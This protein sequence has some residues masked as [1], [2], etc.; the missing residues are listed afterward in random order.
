ML[1]RSAEDIQTRGE[2]S[3]IGRR[4]SCEAEDLVKPKIL[5]HK[6]LASISH[7]FS[8]HPLSQRNR[9]DVLQGPS[10]ISLDSPKPYI[11]WHGRE[12]VLKTIENTLVDFPGTRSE[13]HTSELQSRQY[14]VC[15]TNVRVALLDVKHTHHRFKAF[16]AAHF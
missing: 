14:L 15:H 4:R 3:V 12:K 16:E 7:S 6:Q 9:F 2:G 5:R 13:E 8:S 1:F 11:N 10:L